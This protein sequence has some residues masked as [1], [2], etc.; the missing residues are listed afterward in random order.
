MTPGNAIEEVSNPR[1]STGGDPLASPGMRLIDHLQ[2]APIKVKS[3]RIMDAATGEQLD[4]GYITEPGANRKAKKLQR[5]GV[6]AVV[7]PVEA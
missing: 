3:F 5:K 7:E 2:T 4:Q 6:A 1:T